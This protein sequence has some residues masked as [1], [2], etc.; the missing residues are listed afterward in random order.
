MQSPSNLDLQ[1]KE[2]QK[3]LLSGKYAEAEQAFRDIVQKEKPKNSWVSVDLLNSIGASLHAQRKE[4]EALKFFKQALAEVPKDASPSDLRKAKIFSNMSLLYSAQENTKEA[5][6]FAD[7]ALMIFRANKTNPVELAVLLNSTGKIKLAAGDAPGAES[8][9]AESISLREKANGK[10][11]LSLVTPMVNICGALMEQNKDVEAQTYCQRA[12]LICEKSD[13]QNSAML[14]PVLCNLGRLQSDKKQYKAAIASFIR[15]NKIASIHYG[16]NSEENLLTCF[17]LSEFF[18]KDGQHE[19]AEKSLSQAVD[20]SRIVRGSK[21]SQTIE[22]TL[23][24]AHL[25][26]IHGK[27]K[28]AERLRILCRLSQ[29]S[30]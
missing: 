1:I 13:G 2:A 20:I 18:E 29:K 21:D 3:L 8:L 24:L 25:Y 11:S 7:D 14:F 15:A 16:K 12:I 5:L 26:E 17:A 22:A 9:F 27:D 23:A 4:V 6:K 28:E 10:E 19:M 30:N